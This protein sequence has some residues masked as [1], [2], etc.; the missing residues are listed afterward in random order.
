MF[1]REDVV[2]ELL[3]SRLVRIPPGGVAHSVEEALDV[4]GSVGYPV[5]LRPLDRGSKVVCE[6]AKTLESSFPSA[7]CVMEQNVPLDDGVRLT[8]RVCEERRQALI[9]IQGD[10]GD[11]HIEYVEPLLG[12]D[13]FRA[14][15]LLRTVDWKD[16]PLLRGS[17]I[18]IALYELFET[19]DAERLEVESLAVVEGD[20]FAVHASL[21][22]DDEAR[23]RHPELKDAET[24]APIIHGP[25]SVG[26]VVSG[27]GMALAAIDA[28]AAHDLAPSRVIDLGPAVTKELIAVALHEL[29][30]EKA[31]EQVL[32]SVACCMYPCSDLTNEIVLWHKEHEELPLGV[33]II[34]GGQDEASASLKKADIE[35]VASL[36]KA[37]DALVGGEEE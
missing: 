32:I 14:L 30:D 18:I 12:F 11:E 3:E 27:K 36:G 5:V 10:E 6:N 22:V 23:A 2:R 1:L 4:A 34:G 31:T 24:I 29:A 7:G 37:V 21:Y 20:V 8:M 35:M 26:C 13:A 15:R 17:A 16:Q 19:T 25:G 9:A 28:L 33:H